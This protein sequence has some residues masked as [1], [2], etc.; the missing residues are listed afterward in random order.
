VH[1]Q[2]GVLLLICCHGATKQPTATLAMHPILPMALSSSSPI[3]TAQPAFFFHCCKWSKSASRQHNHPNAMI[4]TAVD[5]ERQMNHQQAILATN[6]W[7]FGIVICYVAGRA[8]F[9]LLQQTCLAKGTFLQ[10]NTHPM[11]IKQCYHG[12]KF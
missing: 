10:F 4:P 2:I 6:E 8:L 9:Q 7:R 11:V 5:W 12:K 1:W 3:T